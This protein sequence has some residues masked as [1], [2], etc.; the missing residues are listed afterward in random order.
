V[1]QAA[2]QEEGQHVDVEHV[3]HL[4]IK[5]WGADH[6]LGVVGAEPAVRHIDDGHIKESKDCQRGSHD[7]GGTSFRPAAHN[8]I[9]QIK[10]PQDQR[11]GEAHIPH[12][13]FTPGIACPDGPGD[14]HHGA[15]NHADFRC[16]YRQRIS[17]G[18]ALPQISDGRRK[19]HEEHGESG[20]GRGN[21]AIEDAL[22]VAHGGFCGRDFQPQISRV[23][24]QAG[25]DYAACEKKVFVHSALSTVSKSSRQAVV[26]TAQNAANSFIWATGD[27]SPESTMVVAVTM[28][29][30]AGM[31]TGSSS[32]GSISSRLRVR[33]DITAKKVPFTPSAHVPS[34]KMMTSCQAEPS[35]LRL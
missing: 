5:A 31:E 15:E 12:P 26:Y 25:R 3:R 14:Q 34:R 20:H 1:N 33:M 7:R 6:R 8:Q 27:P 23:A 29:T 24:E 19:V 18:A 30:T 22:H 16:A 32:R 21:M 11:G 4:R 17:P 9:A 10:Q 28:L 35:A 13:P 2:E